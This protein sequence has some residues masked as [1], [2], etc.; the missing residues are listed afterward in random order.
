LDETKRAFQL[1]NLI[2]LLMKRRREHGECDTR[3]GGRGC[4]VF[5]TSV[6]GYRKK[7]KAPLMVLKRW[8]RWATEGNA[9]FWWIFAALMGVVVGLLWG[10]VGAQGAEVART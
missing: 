1:T 3:I 8:A 7:E 4:L 6:C 10:R 5:G 2:R 9:V